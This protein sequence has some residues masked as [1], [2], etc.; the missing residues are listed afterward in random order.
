MIK[1]RSHAWRGERRILLSTLNEV[2]G[3]SQD[4]LRDAVPYAERLHPH[5]YYE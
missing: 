4:K 5:E 2:V 3:A 1:S